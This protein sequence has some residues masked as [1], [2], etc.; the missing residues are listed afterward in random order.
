MTPDLERTARI[1]IAKPYP[2]LSPNGSPVIAVGC[3]NGL[4]ILWCRGGLNKNEADKHRRDTNGTLVLGASVRGEHGADPRRNLESTGLEPGSDDYDPSELYEAI[5]QPI[6]LGVA[7][8]YL[9]FP[10]IPTDAS[11]QDHNALPPILMQ[12]LLAVV[13]CSDSSVRL[14]I[15]P[16]APPSAKIERTTEEAGESIVDNEDTGAY[17]ETCVVVLGGNGHQ[18]IPRCA[19]LTLAPVAMELVADLDRDDLD[20]QVGKSNSTDRLPSLNFN[21]SLPGDEMNGRL[22]VVESKGTVRVLEFT[23]A[24]YSK[25]C[26]SLVSLYPNSRAAASGRAGKRLL[27]A[28]WVLGGKAIL[29]LADDGE[30]GMWDFGG[31]GCKAHSRTLAPSTPTMG[32]SFTFAISGRVHDGSN[33]A[34]A[35]RSGLK[36][37]KGSRAVKLAPTT[38]TTRRVRQEH[39]F[40]GP[41][42]H[43][44]GLAQGGISMLTTNDTVVIDEAILL[45]HN[46]TMSMIPSLRTHWANKVK[47]SGNLFGNE[48]KGEIRII[49]DFGSKGERHTGIS[50]L[51]ANYG[52]MGQRPLEYAVLVTGETRLI[53]LTS[54]FGGSQSTPAVLKSPPSLD[55][56]GMNRVLSTV[57]DNEQIEQSTTRGMAV[58]RKVGFVNV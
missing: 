50:L 45:W 27:D 15:L 13:V 1:H 58:K 3:E 39:L 11:Q 55:L 51:R 33:T 53:V 10:Y 9:A 12:K 17:R 37:T 52:P 38:P 16:L 14:V 54:P 4:R 29:A 34:Q 24:A 23:S 20:I 35:N 40:T 56:N 46:D 8:L 57:G 21:P 32:S 47:G 42:H 43:T 36:T 25:Q 19:A 28:Q 2:L 48:A 31:H 30:W 22:L 41:P 18:G 26:S 44:E 7:V 49:R 6:N 5:T